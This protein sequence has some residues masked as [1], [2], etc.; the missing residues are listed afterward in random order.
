MDSIKY[1]QKYQIQDLRLKFLKR[2]K[3]LNNSGAS[4]RPPNYLLRFIIIINL[5]SVREHTCANA[6]DSYIRGVEFIAHVDLHLAQ[7]ADFKLQTDSA[8][9]VNINPSE[10]HARGSAEKIF[11]LNFCAF[12][13]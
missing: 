3:Y 6:S 7:A 13:F 4:Q 11:T 5:E 12:Y 10:F 9:D 1:P 8:D 2:Y